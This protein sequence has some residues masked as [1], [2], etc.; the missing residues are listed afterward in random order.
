[1]AAAEL[2]QQITEGERVA[3]L[4]PGRA[5][6][7]RLPAGAGPGARRAFRHRP[8]H[9]R[10]ARPRAG[11][12]ARH[13]R[14]DPPLARRAGRAATARAESDGRDRT[15]RVHPLARPGASSSSARSRS[16]LYGL[17]LLLAI[18]ACIWLT[19][20]RWVRRGGDWDLVF[21]V[22]VWGVAAGIVGARLYHVLTIWNEVPDEWWGVFA[23]WKGGLGVWG[24]IGLGVDRRRDRRAPLRR[25]ASRASWTRRARAA[26]RAGDRAL[27]Q[28]VE[29]GAVRQADRPAVGARDRRRSTGR[30][31]Y[32][33]ERDLPPDLPLRV[34]L[35]PAR[36]GGAALARAR[37]SGSGRRRSSRSTSP[38]TRSAASHRELLRIDPAHEFAGLRLNAWV[39][40]VAVRARGAALRLEAVLGPA[41]PPRAR[42]AEAAAARW[43]C[44]RAASDSGS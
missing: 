24:G 35:E 16:T 34:D 10:R 13:R 18:A 39:S 32:V 14:A 11:L 9:R 12:R 44:R 3:G 4:A 1:M 31:Q 43:P 22:A 23:V 26:A 27:G 33:D 38:G 7:C 15:R 42:R 6:A 36:R 19:G 40:L 2:T 29:P 21:R 37:S 25:R 20:V 5:R 41:P 28:L 17:M 30:P 8:A